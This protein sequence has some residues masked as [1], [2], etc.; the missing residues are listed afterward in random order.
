MQA[1]S[2]GLVNGLLWL[3]FLGALILGILVWR[4]RDS[5]RS[6]KQVMAVNLS[7]A[8]EAINHRIAE[9][10]RLRS[11]LQEHSG[12]AGPEL[13]VLP[14]GSSAAD[15]IARYKETSQIVAGMRG[16]VQRLQDLKTAP[17]VVQLGESLKRSEAETRKRVNAYDSSVRTYNAVRSGIPTVFYADVIGYP[18]VERLDLDIGGSSS[19]P[20]QFKETTVAMTAVRYFYVPSPGAVPKGPVS[21]EDLRVLLEQ[22]VI[23]SSALVAEI[24]SDDWVSIE[25]VAARL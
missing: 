16:A 7:S 25:A 12:W 10:N 6:V 21:A 13:A 22:G 24:G 15:V 3:A 14:A 18:R 19:L 17:E 8:Q 23:Q 2:A 20:D 9:V 1:M 11:V 5:L 4:S